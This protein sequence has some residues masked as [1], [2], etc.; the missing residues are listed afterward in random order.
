[1]VLG[2]SEQG[3]RSSRKKRVPTSL[4]DSISLSLKRSKG[5]RKLVP[6][7]FIPV[8]VYQSHCYA[9][10]GFR[11][12]RPPACPCPRHHALRLSPYLSSRSL[13]FPCRTSQC[14]VSP[15]SGLS[16]RCPGI[17][18]V[19]LALRSSQGTRHGCQQV[20]SLI[21]FSIT[22]L[23]SLATLESSASC[24]GRGKGSCPPC[25]PRFLGKG[26][27]LVS[28]YHRGSFMQFC[29]LAGG[30]R[31]LVFDLAL[32]LSRSLVAGKILAWSLPTLFK[33]QHLNVIL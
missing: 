26:K 14:V 23:V 20:H 1:M 6:P 16:L 22:A 4:R 31:G 5:L 8:L 25:F 9:Q 19:S 29:P 2:F 10:A 13:C 27:P 28:C 21:T 17:M 32:R 33:S 18:L 24:P 30:Q 7:P 11:A 3:A 15:C 12:P